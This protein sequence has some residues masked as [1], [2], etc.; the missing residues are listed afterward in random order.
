MCGRLVSRRYGGGSAPRERESTAGKTLR[1]L[2]VMFI[3]GAQQSVG[4]PCVATKTAPRCESCETAGI[5]QLFVV[6]V[7]GVGFVVCEPCAV[8]GMVSARRV[9][10][11][12]ALRRFIP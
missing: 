8:D 5:D 4:N 11:T 7:D 3:I 9:G 10:R 6:D 12:A 1:L 2:D